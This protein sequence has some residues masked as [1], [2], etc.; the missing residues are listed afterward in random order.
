MRKMILILLVLTVAASSMFAQDMAEKDVPVAVV[1]AF[2]D[3]FPDA[4]SP[5]WKKN[6]SGKY[7]VKFKKEGQKAEAKFMADGKWDS[8]ETRLEASALPNSASDYLKK[9]YGAYKIDQ[10]KWEEDNDAS[11]NKYEVKLKKEKSEI[12]LVFDGEGK[13]LK[14]KDKA[15]DKNKKTKV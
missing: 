6:K 11:K 5:E 10:V 4:A 13:F 7:E 9:N 12:E 14:K 2:K 1:S 8:S 3:K 15:P